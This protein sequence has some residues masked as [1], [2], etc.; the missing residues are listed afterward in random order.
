M[1]Q[2][3]QKNPA[4]AVAQAQSTPQKTAVKPTGTQ[5]MVTKSSGSIFKKW[6][7]WLIVALVLGGAVYFIWFWNQ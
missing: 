6:W 1:V 7:F 3:V 2:K 4:N 5:P